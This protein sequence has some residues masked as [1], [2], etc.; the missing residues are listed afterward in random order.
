MKELKMFEEAPR[1]LIWP[2]CHKVEGF[3]RSSWNVRSLTTPCSIC[4]VLE[5]SVVRVRIHAACITESLDWPLK[6]AHRATGQ[7]IASGGRLLLLSM[8][9]RTFSYWIVN[10]ISKAKTYKEKVHD[11][12]KALG[13]SMCNMSAAL[14][15]CRLCYRAVALFGTWRALTRTNVFSQP[16]SFCP[17]HN[18]S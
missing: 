5:T 16:V 8:R 1:W 6:R 15:Q 7:H 11:L 3:K 4:E 2:F 10:R 12:A 18:T 17:G 9:Q 13:T 14:S